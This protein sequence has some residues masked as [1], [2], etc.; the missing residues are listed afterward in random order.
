MR[1]LY[2]L[3]FYLA[4][5]FIFLRLLW[6]SRKIPGYAKNLNERLG[7]LNKSIPKN[8]VWFHV[9]SVG[10][11]L[12]AVPLIK[13]FQQKYPQLPIIIT[14]TTATGAERVRAAFGAT[15]TQL[16][17][18]YDVPG[19][20]QRFIN[21]VQPRCLVVMETELWPNLFYV[22]AK[23]KIPILIANARL[24]ERSAKGYQ[25]I[26]FL[27]QAMLQQVTVMAVQTQIEAERFIALGLEPARIHVTGSVKFDLEIPANLIQQAKQLRASWNHDQA[28]ERLV[29]IAA[30]THE[31]EEEV[32]LQAFA[33]VQKTLPNLLLVLVPRH[34]DRFT[35][36]AELCKR[37]N[38]NVVLRSTNTICT[39]DTQIF[40]GDTMGELLLLYA[41]ADV[42]FV[43]GSL[44]A[45]GGHNPLEPAAL[46]LPVIMGPHVFNFAAICQELLQTGAMLTVHNAQELATQLIRL[47]QNPVERK[48]M[49]ERGQAFVAQNRGA[50]AKHLVLLEELLKIS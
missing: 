33:A 36:V 28:Q 50:V 34:P 2:T 37:H 46:G 47:L 9:V 21:A 10:E 42:A 7:F 49:G 5:P 25:R 44:V 38:F 32:I 13:A 12:A 3:L 26:R 8:G 11:T 22:C 15:V 20:L 35:R 29:W 43:G 40:L 39:A 6:R 4:L 30:S 41:T 16:Y 23:N 27:T 17:C 1:R 18:P 19:A 45:T 14:S 48:H 24:S 31:G